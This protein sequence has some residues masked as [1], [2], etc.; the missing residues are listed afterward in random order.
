MQT[1]IFRESLDLS[2][3]E[4]LGE[5]RM[6]RNVIL[7]R[8]GM[9]L[10]RRLYSER[11]L[12]DAAP[13]FEG[14][15]AY[16]GHDRDRKVSQLTG[17]YSNVRF[18]DGAL[19]ADRHF[20][21]NDAGRNVMSVVTD[22]VD[23][24]APSKLAGLSISA[25]GKAK[26]VRGKTN[27][28]DYAEVESITAAESVDDVTEPA[29]GGAYTLVAGMAGGLATELLKAFEFEEYIEARPDYV[30]RLKK[31]W[32]TVRQTEALKAAQAES[33][34]AVAGLDEAR[35]QLDRM[36]AVAEAAI[37]ERDKARRE[38]KV[39]DLL[40][41]AKLPAKWKTDLRAQLTEADPDRWADIISAEQRKAEAANYKPRPEVSG[42]GQQVDSGRLPEDT[43]PMPRSNE[44]VSDWLKRVQKG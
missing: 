20:T 28:E 29:A 33:E 43:N 3:S 24:R 35:A 5:Q 42:S 21:Q 39:A 1:S 36:T 32:S 17:W 30:A 41:T 25:V 37:L 8:S 31:E 27:D 12:M 40:A 7:I 26:F 38:L 4:Y 19:R 15:K 14:A 18:E 9:S 22:I 44:N 23:R 16:D 2:E 10:N 13:L 6:L 11:V 34:I